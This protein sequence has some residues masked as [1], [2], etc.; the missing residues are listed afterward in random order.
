MKHSVHVQ[1]RTTIR[2]ID[3]C[4]QIL[5]GS[6]IKERKKAYHYLYCYGVDALSF[7]RCRL[8]PCAVSWL[9]RGA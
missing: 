3:S 5:T 7:V 6:I 9:I 1:C 4:D 2:V 8:E